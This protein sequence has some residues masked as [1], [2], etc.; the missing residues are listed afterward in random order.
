MRLIRYLK[1]QSFLEQRFECQTVMSP[2]KSAKC[3]KILARS[4]I[5]SNVVKKR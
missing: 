4:K 2:I 5:Y 1:R 3:V